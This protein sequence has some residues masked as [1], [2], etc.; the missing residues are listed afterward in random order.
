MAVKRDTSTMQLVWS[1]W[2]GVGTTITNG[3]RNNEVWQSSARK[4]T[5]PGALATGVLLPPAAVCPAR[6]CPVL[7]NTG[8]LPAITSHILW[9]AL[10][11]LWPE[12][13]LKRVRFE[14]M[15]ISLCCQDLSS[16][17]ADITMGAM[18]LKDEDH[19][20]KILVFFDYHFRG[21]WKLHITAVCWRLT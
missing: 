1:Y 16:G 13:E 19:F 11:W 5:Q 6:S 18:M 17:H 4:P 14:P 3:Q 10:Q 20:Q 21:T 9:A 12:W 8:C 15:T 7:T 2:G